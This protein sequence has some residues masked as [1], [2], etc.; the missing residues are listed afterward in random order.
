MLDCE[1]L[2]VSWFKKNDQYMLDTKIKSITLPKRRKV[3]LYWRG[4]KL[5]R[6]PCVHSSSIQQCFHCLYKM[7]LNVMQISRHL[8]LILFISPETWLIFWILNLWSIRTKRPP[9]PQHSHSHKINQSIEPSLSLYRT[10][11]EKRT[12]LM[13][14]WN[15]LLLFNTF[16][17]NKQF[18]LIHWTWNK[19]I[20]NTF[21]SNGLIYHI[22][23]N[24]IKKRFM[25][26]IVL[27]K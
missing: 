8:F 10:W 23:E 12:L 19:I 2:L 26:F 4:K 21:Y 18:K 13:K 11:K 5:I 17:W 9:P 22:S 27:T 20:E 14:Q 7:S 15:V 3:I 1:T 25:M 24:E 16:H 6:I